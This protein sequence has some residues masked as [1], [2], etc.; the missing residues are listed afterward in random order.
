MTNYYEAHLSVISI[1]RCLAA[2]FERPYDQTVSRVPRLG[3][4]RIRKVDLC[5]MTDACPDPN[6]WH[7]PVLLALDFSPVV[8]CDALI[9]SCTVAAH[10]A[11]WCCVLT[12]GCTLLLCDD[13]LW[14]VAPSLLDFDDYSCPQCGM[15][16]VFIDRGRGI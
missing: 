1:A 13:I 2:P 3:G 16:G 14:V 8:E 4:P 5:V 11:A 7:D 6:W 9:A 12:C 10:P 15:P